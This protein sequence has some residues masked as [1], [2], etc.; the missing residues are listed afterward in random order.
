[1]TSS[2]ADAGLLAGAGA[3]ASLTVWRRRGAAGAGRRRAAAGT[4]PGSRG[5]AAAAAGTLRTSGDAGSRRIHRNCGSTRRYRSAVQATHRTDR[6]QHTPVLVSSTGHTQ[7]RQTAAY[8]GTG[9]QYRPHTGQTDCSTRRY[10]SAVQARHRTHRP[11]HTPVQVSSTGHT[12]DRQTAAHAGTGQ[13]YRPHTGQT[14]CSTR[15]YRSV[16]QATH[17]TDR[18]QHTPVQV[19]STGHTQDRQTAA[20]AGT[21]QQYRP[22]TG[23]TDCSTRRYRSAV[24]AT[25]RTERLQHTPVQV[26]STGHTQ[27]RQTA[28]HAGTG[29]QYRP[30]TGQTD[31]STRRYWSAV[32]A[33]H[34][35]DRLQHTPVQRQQYRPHTGKTDCSTRRYRSVVQATHRTDRL[36]HTPVQVSST[37]HTQDRQTA[38]HA[39]TGQQYRSHTGQTDRSTRRYRSAVQA[40]HRTDRLQHTPVL[41]SI[42]GHTEDR[43]TAAHAG[44]GQQYRPHRG[45]TD[46][47]TRR[48]RSAVQ[49]THRT[50]IL[51]DT[52]VLVSSTGHTQDRQTAAHTGTGQQYRSH[53]GQT[54]RSTRRY[55]SAV[56]ATH[57]TDRLQHTP[58]LVSSTG[59]TQDRQFAAHAGT[60][61]QYRPH[62]GQTDCSTRRYRSVVQAT[63]RTDRPQ[64]TPVLV[65][66]T[67]HTQDRQTAAH[68]GTGQQLTGHTQGRQT[69][70]HAGTGQQYRSHT[71]QTRLQ[72]TPVQV[73]STGQTQGRQTAAHAGTGQQYRPHTGQTDCST[74]RYRSAVQAT[75]R[76]D[77]PQ[78][79]P[80]QVRSAVQATHRTDRLQHTPVLVSSTGHTQDRQTAA[81]AGTG[82]QYRPH[83]GQ[84][85]CS[86]RR[87]WSAVQATQ[88]TDRLQHTPVQVSS[89]GHT[90][91]RQTAA[92]AGTGQQYRPHTGQTDCSTRR[93]RSAVQATHRTDRL[94]H[95]PV[96]VSSTGH[97]Q[98]RQTA[99]HA[100]TG[101]Q[102]RPHTGQTD[103]S[104]RRYRSA[105]QATHRTDRLQHTPVQVSN[106]GHTQLVNGRQHMSL[107]AINTADIPWQWVTIGTYW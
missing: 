86:T 13:Q 48:Y 101:Q 95:T 107:P 66:S 52:P 64:H 55:R 53:T 18:L 8:A 38:A 31:C 33:T 28:A 73:S 22:H 34:R 74:R 1:M 37:G 62:T 20:H 21:G 58:V 70:A 40:T 65:S 45:Q 17:R 44:S 79:T 10:R 6:P 103:C 4:A 88:R 94:Q 27:D 105:V 104:T 57:R 50:D 85:D 7:N 19:S 9:Q 89:T 32:Q 83:R 67:G 24:Q 30:H 92:H 36:Q 99:A 100:G 46:C 15:R 76:T 98:D 93:Y 87:Y 56:Q 91:D 80:V 14:D 63:H 47:S 5:R 97:T 75:H 29:Q 106:I 82:Q 54:Y 77:R 43:Q 90:Q 41:V 16:V 23:Q 11:Q 61:Q 2:A 84:T 3:G 68:A 42:S 51:Q 81:H 49:A 102:Y 35:T 60:G 26:S 25:H 72:H 96:Q 59:H 78:H 12:Q 39:G 71:G 69:A